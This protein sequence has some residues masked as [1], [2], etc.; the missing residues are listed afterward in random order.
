MFAAKAAKAQ[1]KADAAS[2]DYAMRHRST[3]AAPRENLATRGVSWD[4]GKIPLFPPERPERPRAGS[5]LAALPAGQTTQMKLTIGSAGDLAEEE[6]NR[7]ANQVDAGAPPAA[8]VPA[9]PRDAGPGAGPPPAPAPAPAPAP[10]PAPAPAPAPPAPAATI[11]AVTFRGSSNRIAPTR[12]ATVP[13]T[14]TNLAAGASATIDVEG[15]GGANGTATVTA[16]GT[17]AGSGNVT[18][19]GD[20]QTTPGHAGSLMLRATAGGAVIGRSAGFTVAARP[21]DFT[22]SRN[23][24][25]DTATSVGLRVNIACVSDGSGALAELNEC[26][27]TERVDIGSRDNPPFTSEGAISATGTGTSH[28][29]AA[30]A[31]P[32]VDTHGYARANID[33]STLA[34]GLFNLVYQQNFLLNDR[35]TGTMGA[36]VQNS[37]FTITHSVFYVAPVWF[38]RTAKTGA[39]VTVEGKAATAGSGTATSNLHTL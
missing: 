23:A 34:G 8:G 7:I 17:L 9:G 1:T 6:A 3:L 15:S 21:A 39:A 38:H 18:V 32:L 11:G 13:V 29:M 28:F 35:R 12:T 22:I 19:R 14:L 37:G 25:R 30:T 20:A 4:F 27:H 10:L 36:V 16:G 5:R 26:E 31:S 24:D 33:K 2:P